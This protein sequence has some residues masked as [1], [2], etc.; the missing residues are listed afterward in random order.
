MTTPEF[1][2]LDEQILKKEFLIKEKDLM[3]WP[4]VRWTVLSYLKFKEQ[5]VTIPHA[6][7]NKLSLK[8]AK[9]LYHS[10]KYAPH[11][12]KKTYDIIY[13]ASA[14]GR[15]TNKNFN[16]LTDYYAPLIPEA[17]V[18]DTSYGGSYKIP[19]NTRNFATGEYGQLRMLLLGQVKKIISKQKNQVIERFVDFL[20][21]YN[22]IEK[23]FLERV[24]KDLYSYYLGYDYYRSYITKV[25]KKLKPRIIFVHTSTYTGFKAILLKIAKE[26]GI[27]TAEFQHGIISKYHIPYNYAD[28]VFKSEE[29]KK[30]LPDYIL[31]FGDFWNKNIKIPSKIITIGYPHFYESMKKYQK[32]KEIS[33]SLLIISQG[34]LTDEFVQIAKYLSKNYPNYS[35]IFKLHPGEIPFENRYKQLDN[36]SNIKIAKSGDIYQYIAE[37]EYILACYS[38]AIFETLGFNKKLLLLDNELS[39]SEIPDGIGVRF[40]EFQELNLNNMKFDKNSNPE[41]Y[42]DRNW[43][44]NYMNF[45]KKEANIK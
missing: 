20:K 7:L 9:L 26:N 43:E 10:F 21:S 22:D 3:I 29:Y 36:Y 2:D 19:D 4:L 24:K 18:I 35:I 15:L 30:Y 45:V 39:R 23:V 38:T 1:F 33:H 6:R 37:S 44:E 12:L 14:R 13:Y 28:A 11:R 41:Y 5:N 32:V 42:F 40:K 8:N 27:I 16:V 31:T 34:T 17:L 25:F